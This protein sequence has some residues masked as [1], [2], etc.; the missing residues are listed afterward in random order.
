MPRILRRLIAGAGAAVAA[1]LL[2]VGC[3]PVSQ[4]Q[5]TLPGAADGPLPLPVVLVDRTG[6]VTGIGQPPVGGGIGMVE[7]VSNVPGLPGQPDMLLVSFTSGACTERAELLLEPAGSGYRLALGVV[8]RPGAC[9]GIGYGRLLAI[10]LTI[11]VDAR[12]V[13]LDGP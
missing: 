9:E 11:A 7:G 2:L 10:A 4:W 6:L 1:A 12:L 3:M 8:D 5:T 13:R